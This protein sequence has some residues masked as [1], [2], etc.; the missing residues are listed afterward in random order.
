MD[1]ASSIAGLIGLV[2]VAAGTT[3]K[4]VNVIQDSRDVSNNL[5]ARLRTLEQHALLLKDLEINYGRIQS[6]G[7]EVDTRIVELHIPRCQQNIRALLQ[8]LESTLDEIGR[9][10]GLGRQTKKLMIVSKSSRIE[11]QFRLVQD[12]FDALENWQVSL[13]RYKSLT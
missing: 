7:I 10:R 11:R 2:I 12:N 4:L 9:A 3:A 6:L 1:V 5:T 13:N 8:N